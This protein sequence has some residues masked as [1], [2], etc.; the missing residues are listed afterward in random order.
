M[1]QIVPKNG[2]SPR[3]PQSPRHLYKTIR[4]FLGT[5]WGL[6]GI[7]WKEPPYFT[8]FFG[9]FWGSSPRRRIRLGGYLMKVAARFLLILRGFLWVYSF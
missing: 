5:F 8:G 9:L 2:K 1:I 6:L 3:Q 4:A 7:L